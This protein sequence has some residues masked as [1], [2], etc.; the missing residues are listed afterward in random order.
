MHDAGDVA[1]AVALAVGGDGGNFCAA[2]RTGC[3]SG[4]NGEADAGADLWIV[5]G[6]SSRRRGRVRRIGDAGRDRKPSAGKVIAGLQRL[7]ARTRLSALT[8]RLKA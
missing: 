3:L 6:I 5:F 2:D 7:K 8:L 4:V 1:A